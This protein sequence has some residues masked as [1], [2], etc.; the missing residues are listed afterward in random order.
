M[1]RRVLCPLQWPLILVTKCE[2]QGIS[3]NL[4][5]GIKPKNLEFPIIFIKQQLKLLVASKDQQAKKKKKKNA[6]GYE[7]GQGAPLVQKNSQKEDSEA[8]LNGA[9]SWARGN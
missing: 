9:P 6:T 4:L 1:P 5:S 8:S 3:L 2:N 7:V